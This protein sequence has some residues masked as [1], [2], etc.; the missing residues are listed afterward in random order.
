MSAAK[1]HR[2]VQVWIFSRNSQG[3]EVCLLLKTNKA[4]GQFWQ[5]V[6]GTVEENEGYF[7][8]ACREALEETGFSFTAAPL[9][10]G[11][12]FDFKSRFGPARERIFALYVD[13]APAPKLDP[14]EHD[15][16]RWLEPIK[17]AS[18]LRFPSNYEGLVQSFKQ[19]FGKE[20]KKQ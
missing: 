3:A 15:D 6:T 12:E 16:S 14:R 11:Y 13:D 2:K 18:L 10:T 5:P 7:E 8:A 9:D 19:M 20:L 17:A 1:Y 4:R